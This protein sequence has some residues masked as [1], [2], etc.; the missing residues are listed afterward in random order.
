MSETAKRKGF[1]KR[2]HAADEEDDT[3]EALGVQRKLK[4]NAKKKQKH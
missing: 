3:E 2:S 4:K 1:R